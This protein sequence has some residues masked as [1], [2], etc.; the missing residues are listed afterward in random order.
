MSKRCRDDEDQQES[1][2]AEPIDPDNPPLKLGVK[3]VPWRDQFLKR[4]AQFRAKQAALKKRKP[5]PAK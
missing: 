2:P 3:L 5:T 4:V 1:E